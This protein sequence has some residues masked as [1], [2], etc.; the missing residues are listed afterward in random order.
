ME[1]TTRSQSAPQDRLSHPRVWAGLVALRRPCLFLF[2][3]ARI[4]GLS[5]EVGRGD[6]RFLR[7]FRAKRMVGGSRM[8]TSAPA[9]RSARASGTFF[10]TWPGYPLPGCS[11]A[12][13]D[14][15][16]PGNIQCRRVTPRVP[17]PLAVP[18]QTGILFVLPCLE[19]APL[20]LETTHKFWRGAFFYSTETGLPSVRTTP[21]LAVTRGN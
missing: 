13:P 1:S 17:H 2:L 11:P 19:H 5:D 8:R 7:H 6:R 16:S 3:L 21:C 15:V 12:E 18:R 10:P 20:H 9:E 4:C 14:S